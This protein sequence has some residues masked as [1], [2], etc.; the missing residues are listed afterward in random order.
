MALFTHTILG[1]TPKDAM[2]RSTPVAIAGCPPAW[3][4]LITALNE[5]T[6]G[7]GILRHFAIETRSK[8]AAS[9]DDDVR[10][11]PEGPPEEDGDELDWACGEEAWAA[12][13]A[14]SSTALARSLCATT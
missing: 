9:S 4:A 2:S 1:S 8:A 12:A 13:A 3:Q 7:A 14:A 5:A 11:P 10:A 6:S